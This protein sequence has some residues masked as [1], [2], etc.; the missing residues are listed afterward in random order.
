M[1]QSAAAGRRTIPR[2]G[3]K[4]RPFRGS[5]FEAR[6]PQDL[7]RT[8]ARVDPLVDRWLHAVGEDHVA[9]AADAAAES[10]QPVCRG[11]AIAGEPAAFAAGRRLRLA[12]I[13]QRDFIVPSRSSSAFEILWAAGSD[14]ASVP[15]GSAEYGNVEPP[16]SGNT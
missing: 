1:N 13:V 11:R 3:R 8:Q 2:N 5:K 9:A 10:A 16:P 7:V 14:D 4:L 6:R 15:P 12:L